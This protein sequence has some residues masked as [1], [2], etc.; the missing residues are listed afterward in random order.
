MATVFFEKHNCDLNDDVWSSPLH[1]SNCS[2]LVRWAWCASHRRCRCANINTNPDFL[3]IANDPDMLPACRKPPLHTF[4]PCWLS[5]ANQ[6]LRD[7]DH[8]YFWRRLNA[9]AAW[10]GGLLKS[11]CYKCH[12]SLTDNRG[13]PRRSPSCSVP[14]H[15]YYHVNTRHECPYS[16][17]CPHLLA[18]IC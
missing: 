10:R 15:G 16:Q 3:L 11:G 9:G 4:L 14:W 7:S 13:I 6:Q 1:Y 2:S 17:I 8:L 5:W 12:L 18:Q